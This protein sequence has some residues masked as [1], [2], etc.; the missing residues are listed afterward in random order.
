MLLSHPVPSQL[1]T[2][3]IKDVQKMMRCAYDTARLAVLDEP[4]VLRFGDIR[5][6][7]CVLKTSSV[8]GYCSP[9]PSLL[10]YDHIAARLR[11]CGCFSLTTH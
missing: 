5:V 7:E 9:S 1:L 10:E 8:A 4:G 6:P 11:T 2:Y 3:T